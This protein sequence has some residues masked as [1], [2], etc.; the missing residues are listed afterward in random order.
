MLSSHQS[1]R[2]YYCVHLYEIGKGGRKDLSEAKTVREGQWGDYIQQAR[3]PLVGRRIE[4]PSEYMQK[5]NERTPV[6]SA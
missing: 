3:S 6:Q 2:Y 5:Q 1:D 4:K